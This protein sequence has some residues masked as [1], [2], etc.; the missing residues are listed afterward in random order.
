MYPVFVC[1]SKKTYHGGDILLAA[2]A[3]TTDDQY[4][5]NMNANGIASDCSVAVYL[6]LILIKRLFILHLRPMN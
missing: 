1:V 5:V 3:N 4:F 6:Y 2:K